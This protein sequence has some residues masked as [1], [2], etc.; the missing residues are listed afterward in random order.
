MTERKRKH[1]FKAEPVGFVDPTPNPS[2]QFEASDDERLLT[3]VHLRTQQALTGKVTPRAACLTVFGAA[4]LCVEAGIEV[5]KALDAFKAEHERVSREFDKLGL[6]PVDRLIADDRRVR[7]ARPAKRQYL[8]QHKCCVCSK[9]VRVYDWLPSMLL[10]AKCARQ[11]ARNDR[12]DPAVK[13]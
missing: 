10:C 4:L 3:R 12:H 7:R 11:E 9:V 13:E 1:R 6:G 8:G 5:S 2:K